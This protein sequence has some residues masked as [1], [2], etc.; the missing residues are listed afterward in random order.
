MKTNQEL[1]AKGV[2]ASAAAMTSPMF[3]KWA[4]LLTVLALTEF[5]VASQ[6][7]DLTNSVSDYSTAPAN[8]AMRPI[9]DVPGLPRML[10][11]GDSISI[12]YTLPVRERLAGKANVHR[13]PENGGP[14]TNGLAR[15][16]AWLGTQ[17]WDV[18][19]FNWGLARS[20]DHG[21][22]PSAGVLARL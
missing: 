4:F 9:Q 16:D 13:I 1:V 14:T 22:R 18:I 17:R 3:R 15:L 6:T 10:L 7:A 2:S 12:G 19:H 5:A 8:P 20:E 11:I 21:Q